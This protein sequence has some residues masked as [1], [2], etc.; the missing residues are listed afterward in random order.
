MIEVNKFAMYQISCSEAAYQDSQ[1]WLRVLGLSVILFNLYMQLG[2]LAKSP[3]DAL[4]INTHL[5]PP[6]PYLFLF[7]SLFSQSNHDV[8]SKDSRLPRPN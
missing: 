5:K 1:Q 6:G 7:A 3:I 2:R 4:H 8:Y